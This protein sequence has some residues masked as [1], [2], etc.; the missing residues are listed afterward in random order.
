LLR[1]SLII[2][3]LLL[4]VTAAEDA[5]SR[6]T[7]CPVRSLGSSVSMVTGYGPDGLGSVLGKGKK[8]LSALQRLTSYTKGTGYSFP[9]NKLAGT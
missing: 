3:V 2:L 5:T 7:T 8:Y 6:I 1:V 9:D 4:M